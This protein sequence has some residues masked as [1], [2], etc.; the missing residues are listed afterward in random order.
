MSAAVSIDGFTDPKFNDVREAL[1]QNL[2]DGA[3]IG[4]A[5][6]VVINGRTV[7]DLWAGYKDRERTQPWERD[8]LV[9]TVR[10]CISR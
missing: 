1:A 3:E 9:C 7:V 10:M 5:V 8:T 6:A 2:C 4:E